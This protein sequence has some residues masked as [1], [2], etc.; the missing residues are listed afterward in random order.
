MPSENK[1]ADPFK[2]LRWSDLEDWAGGK[3]TEKGIK[4][5][6][7]ERVKELKRTPEGSLVARVEGTKEY[8]TEISLKNGKL[9]S[10]CTCPVGHDCKHG[11]AAVLEYLE[12]TEHGEE[13]PVISEEDPFV[14]RARQGYTEAEPPLK[15]AEKF[16]ARALREYLEQLTKKELI[17]ILVAFAEKDALLD[18]YLRD[19]QSLAAEDVEEI[20]GE[21]YS[22]L[23]ELL[24]ETEYPDYVSYEIDVPDFLDVQVGLE[25]L[26][27]AGHPDEL[28]DVG[29]ELMDRYEKIAEYD[30]EGEIG[31]KIS[32]CMDVVL[33]AL[34]QSSLPAHEK[35]LYMLEIELRDNYNI[36]NEHAF[37]EG[38]FTPEE[39]KR[40]AEA[41]KVKL[42][43]AEEEEN[44]LYSPPWQRD[45]AVD[46]LID[47]LGKAGLSEEIIPACESEAEKTGNYIRLV[48]LLLDSGQKKKAEEWIYR[49]IKKTREYQPGTARQLWQ[50]LLELRE[51]EGD[52]LFAT[53]LEAEE[54]FR[55]PYTANYSGMK[56]A[57]RNAGVWQEVREAALNYLKTGELPAG[58]AEASQIKGKEE[59]SG[60]EETSILP[61]ILP[62]TG[63]PE[64][65]SIQKIKTPAFDLLIEIAIQEE[66]PEEVA[67]WYEELKKSGE[68]ADSYWRSISENKIA[69]A[70]KEKYPEIALEIWK[71][72]AEKLIS[73]TKVSSYEEAAPYLRKVKETLE[74]RGRKEEWEAYLSE[75][76]EVNRRKKRL[77]EILDRLGADRIIGE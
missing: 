23:D 67:H 59:I 46:R 51:E 70:V 17:E 40:F 24:E 31:A 9:S 18:R 25:S 2:E 28:L 16:S 68:R 44:S 33:E 29:K 72:L 47:A 5:Q 73:E 69:N 38:A 52:W 60:K 3:A 7:E 10:V 56:E 1:D 6:E 34:S 54:F 63:L 14:A 22:E 66:D 39:W 8:F 49:G 42:Q 76:K 43:E 36:L 41:L 57:A 77:L 61:C 74:A 45:Y 75:I 26:L 37:W 35:M 65:G 12:L 4:Y 53:A 71:Q 64:V 13:I 58:Q 27:D 20:I 48:E 62:K 32:S 15:G 11:V 55:A 21:V 30:E 50:I 19:R